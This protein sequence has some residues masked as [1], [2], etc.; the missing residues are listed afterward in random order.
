MFAKILFVVIVVFLLNNTLSSMREMV[1]HKFLNVVLVSLAIVSVLAIV[2]GVF[3]DVEGMLVELFVDTM[4]P[5]SQSL[6]ELL[7]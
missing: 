2:V 1:G 7:M 6:Q 4:T 3:V 5:S